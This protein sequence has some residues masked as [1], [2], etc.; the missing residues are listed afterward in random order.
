MEVVRAGNYNKTM[1]EQNFNYTTTETAITDLA[2]EE[3]TEASGLDLGCPVYD[4]FDR[5]MLAFTGYWVDGVATTLV[6]TAG[7]KFKIYRFCD[8]QTVTIFCQ[9]LLPTALRRTF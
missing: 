8:I 9:D 3:V 2:E 6:A 5:N 4:D 7:T 1:L